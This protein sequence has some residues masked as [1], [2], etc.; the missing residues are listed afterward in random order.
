MPVCS[1][2]PTFLCSLLSREKLVLCG[3]YGVRM[4]LSGYI[5]TTGGG[6]KRPE[7]QLTACELRFHQTSITLSLF[8]KLSALKQRISF[9]NVPQRGGRAQLM[10]S[11]SSWGSV[12]A[13]RLVSFM[14]NNWTRQ[15]RASHISRPDHQSLPLSASPLTALRGLGSNSPN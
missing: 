10:K 15:V 2:F 4:R 12:E 14:V 5:S 3:P 9:P 8:S 13:C 7:Q 6:T 1:S 11:S